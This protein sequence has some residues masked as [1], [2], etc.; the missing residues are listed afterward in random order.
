[1]F[2][3]D[4]FTCEIDALGYRSQADTLRKLIICCETPYAVGISGRWGSGKTSMMKYLMASLGGKP[5]SHRLQYQS[6]LI[7][8]AVEDKQFE[9]VLT[10][11]VAEGVSTDS[12][13]HIVPIWF[14][15]WEHENQD[16][17]FVEL[18]REI[19]HF[20]SSTALLGQ[21]GK[22][23]ATI[24]R[25]GL[26]ILGNFL[27]VGKNPASHIQDLGEQHEY[28]HFTYTHRS[29]QFKLLFQTA[30]KNL[31]TGVAG[32]G[33]VLDANARL[34]IFIDDLDRCEEA[35]IGRLLK[36]I[37]QHLSTQHCVFV[38]G[39]DRHHIEKSL[40]Q[41][42]DRSLKE[43]R[44]YLE[45]LFQSTVYLKQPTEQKL[46]TYIQHQLNP[47]HSEIDFVADWE[48]EALS[49]FLL[50]ILDPN[51]RRIKAFFT[52][53]YLHV[54]TNDTF[55]HEEVIA[56]DHLKK[57][58]LLTYLKLFYEPVYAALENDVTILNA[59]IAVFQTGNDVT[60]DS[61]PQCFVYLEVLGH[62]SAKNVVLEDEQRH[63][64]LQDAAS[65]QKFLTEV[66]EMQ[67]KHK[68]FRTLKQQFLDCFLDM[69]DSPER[70]RPYL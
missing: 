42:T 45:K 11:L 22:V 34:V 68:S 26:D 24:I 59:L 21:V 1:M 15:P 13:R 12:I 67:G 57:F 70:I 33:G 35:V 43:S 47:T 5:L 29:Q 62:L 27:K 31:L 50:G 51:P 48:T 3:N 55:A 37:K 4:E 32:L 44:S 25:A 8:N 23:A 66:H 20:F 17:P 7:S 6:D 10:Q 39:Y 30:V 54:K 19:H 41:N 14:N 58:A 36:D 69:N 28:T 63:K 53:F 2:S 9:A 46:T 60:L 64:I 49:I 65:E 61:Y 56:L 16:E 18:L 52:S 38:F 40:C